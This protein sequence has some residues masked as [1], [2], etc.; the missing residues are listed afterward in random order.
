MTEDTPETTMKIQEESIKVQDGF[1]HLIKKLD[2]SEQ[3][4][5]NM[6]E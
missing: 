4:V 1:E 5:N 3:N 6:K 2:I